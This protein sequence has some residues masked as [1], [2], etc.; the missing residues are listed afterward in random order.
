MPYL[1]SSGTPDL[2]TLEGETKLEDYTPT[3]W[4]LLAAIPGFPFLLSHWAH[5]LPFKLRLALS[6]LMSGT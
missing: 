5:I 4:K 3:P 6:V 1:C 2:G